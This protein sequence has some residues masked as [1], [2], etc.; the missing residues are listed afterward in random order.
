MTCLDQVDFMERLVHP[1]HLRMR[2]MIWAEEEIRLGNI[3]PS[4]NRIFDA[5]LYRGELPR[6][7]VGSVLGVGERQGRRVVAALI[8]KDVITSSGHNTPIR[9]AFPASLAS[10][11]MPGLFPDKTD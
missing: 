8:E 10:R 4:S 7:E 3:P 5:F 1:D 11:W 9:L 6:G 2:I